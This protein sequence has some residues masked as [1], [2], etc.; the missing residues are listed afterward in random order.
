MKVKEKEKK[1]PKYEQTNFN[2]GFSV[3]ITNLL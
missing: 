2:I 3:G 1:L